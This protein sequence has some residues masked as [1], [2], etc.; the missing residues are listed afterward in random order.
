[1]HVPAHYN[2]MEKVGEQKQII[3]TN[4][5]SAPVKD[6]LWNAQEA[7]TEKIKIFDPGVGQENVLRHFFF[8]KSPMLARLPRP[9]KLDIVNQNRRL[10]ETTLWADGLIIR[11]DKPLEVHTLKNAKKISKA[12][13]QEMLKN[14]ADFVIL[15]LAVP[16]AGV[17]VREQPNRAI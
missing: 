14:R 16:R 5:K 13:Y 15:C 10:I 2:F 17:T 7:E 11:Y 4:A 9:S 12:L 3:E 6:I 1:M 8:K